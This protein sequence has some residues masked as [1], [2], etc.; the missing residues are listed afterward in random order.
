[1]AINAYGFLLAAAAGFL[2]RIGAIWLRTPNQ[3]FIQ[4]N[5]E[6]FLEFD[7]FINC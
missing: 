7:V 1:M 4:R 5:P 3:I 2:E 6:V